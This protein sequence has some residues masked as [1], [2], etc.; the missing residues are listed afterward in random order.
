M[1]AAFEAGLAELHRNRRAQVRSSSNGAHCCIGCR[2]IPE[3]EHALKRF[4]RSA[5]T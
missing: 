2:M 5:P 4:R 3:S 1:G